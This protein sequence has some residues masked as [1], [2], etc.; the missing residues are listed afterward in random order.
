MVLASG[1]L[2][3]GCAWVL[4][5]THNTSCLPCR[6][7]SSLPCDF[8]KEEHALTKT[9]ARAPCS[10]AHRLALSPLTQTQQ[11]MA[12]EEGETHTEAAAQMQAA[13]QTKDMSQVRTRSLAHGAKNGRLDCI[14]NV[15][16]PRVLVLVWWWSLSVCRVVHAQ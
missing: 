11:H 3:L 6:Y 15:V 16:R 9:H 8:S 14:S 7:T 12:E 13:M 10:L 5:C 4:V 1:S 2:F